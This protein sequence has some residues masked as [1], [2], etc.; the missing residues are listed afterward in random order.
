MTLLP[1][2]PLGVMDSLYTY[3]WTNSTSSDVSGMEGFHPKHN[4]SL[5]ITSLTARHNGSYS[6]TV[7]VGQVGSAVPYTNNSYQ[8][9]V[10]GTQCLV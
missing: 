6:L 5:S 4:G 3:I 10:Q 2:V 7:M 8:L 9:Q 1:V